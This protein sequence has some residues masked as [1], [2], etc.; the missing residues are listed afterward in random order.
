M[1]VESSVSDKSY[2]QRFCDYMK[3]DT[4]GVEI[5]TYTL[6]GV[7]LVVAYN[8]V[9][10]ITRFSKP[11]DIPKHFIREQI[12]QYGRV[13]KIE[14]SLQSGPLLMVKH[15]PPLNLIFWSDKTIPV[16]V[17]GIDVNANGYSWLQSVVVNRQI[18]F[19]PVK[20]ETSGNYAEC[21]VHFY[22]RSKQGKTS[23][24]V[25]VGQALLSLGFAKMS[26]PVPKRHPV[27]ASKDPFESHIQSYFKSLARSE[28]VAKDRR[29][30][31]WQQSLPPRMWPV[32]VWHNVLDGLVMRFRPQ[33]HRLPE[34]VR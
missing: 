23:R 19:I 9:R 32:K 14:P 13:Q 3:R 5:A 21:C 33:S 6:S 20:G 18:T 34:L 2:F 22:D 17:A 28:N 4:K 30:G 11:S 1:A 8:K 24:R 12:P 25:D 31:L 7:L 26:V 15:R 27:A 29:V 10:P 16:K